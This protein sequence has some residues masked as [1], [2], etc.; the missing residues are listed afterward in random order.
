[1]E[2]NAL[3]AALRGISAY[4]ELTGTAIMFNA[5]TL[6]DALSNR[7]GEDALTAYTALFY[8]LRQEGYEGLGDWLRDWLRYTETPY[9]R[10]IDQGRSDPALENAARRDIDTL[11]LLAQTDC[12]RFIDA[13]KPL[14]PNEFAPVLAGLPRWKA[15]AP[16]DFDS[17]TR[18]Y[19][20]HGAGE[21]AKYRAFLWEDE[22]LIPV[23][24][25][26]CPRP[27]DLLGYEHQRGMVE[28]NT[29][30]MLAGRQANNVLLFGDGG[31]GKSATVKSMLYLPG[32]EDLR[33]IEVEKGNLTGMPE[34]IRSLA[35][36]RQKFILFIDDLAFDQDDKT[37]SALK[38]ILEGS[39]E[40]RPV[41]V[42]I[43]ATSNR[44]HLVR[45]TFADRAGDE[46]DTFETISEKT[47]LAERFG[48]RIPYLTMNKA[49]Y[50]ALVDH[51]AAQAGIS[52]DPEVLHA[53]AMTWEIRH[54]GRTPRVARQF[55]AS[56]S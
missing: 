20:E 11:V 8:T 54:A 39:L 31:T 19:R 55:V 18:F 13:M 5:A 10:L 37:Y 51:L 46:V 56:L 25:P 41:N 24:D 4:R 48:L 32:M 7:E 1:M 15:A 3:R 9:S 50:L 6:L 35:G 34:L 36:R 52:M 33:L 16:F 44:R 29:R 38:T 42:A 23:A 40:K 27:Q 43:Y 2:L 14:L 28:E 30:L 45:Q 26:D 12:D 21:F 53:Q 49:G 47:A 22:M 17:L